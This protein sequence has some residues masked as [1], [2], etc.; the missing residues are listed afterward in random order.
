MANWAALQIATHAIGV[1][2]HAGLNSRRLF[3][4]FW[5]VPGDPRY[6]K[7]L[8]REILRHYDPVLAEL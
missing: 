7:N 3:R 2:A 1:N 5:G 8:N 4:A 6:S